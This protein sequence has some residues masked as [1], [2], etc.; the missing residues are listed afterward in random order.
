MAFRAAWSSKKNPFDPEESPY[1]RV[2][3]PPR[4][5]CEKWL[6][7]AGRT[8]LL[9]KELDKLVKYYMC[10]DHFERDCFYDAETKTRLKKTLRPVM[11]PIPTIFKC[12]LANVIPKNVSRP[13]PKRPARQAPI[14][15]RKPTKEELPEDTP[16]SSPPVTYVVSDDGDCTEVVLY[17]EQNESL[18]MVVCRLCNSEIDNDVNIT[19]IFDDESVVDD[20]AIV[21]PGE[22]SKDDGFSQYVCQPCI[23]DLNTSRTILSRFRGIQDMLR[24]TVVV[25]EEVVREDS[26]QQTRNYLLPTL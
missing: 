12:N 15:P 21:L 6:R 23:E 22:I 8:D 16:S 24:E 3:H 5:S 7:A 19:Y 1:Y 10:S 14:T 18:E 2:T 4:F 13:I 26:E 20:L 17:D 11:V 25:H 9:D